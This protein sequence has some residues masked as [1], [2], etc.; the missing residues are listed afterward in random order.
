MIEVVISFSIHQQE[1]E[2]SFLR[3]YH[4]TAVLFRKRDNPIITRLCQIC[5]DQTDQKVKHG[6]R[7]V[8]ASMLMPSG[9]V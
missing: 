2:F 5:P 1:R 8:A 6:R 3:A 4:A 9:D 7:R